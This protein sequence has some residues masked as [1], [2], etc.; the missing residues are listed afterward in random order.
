VRL[1]RPVTGGQK[2]NFPV[3]LVGA[4]PSPEDAKVASGLARTG[5]EKLLGRGDFLAVARG[6]TLRFQAAFISERALT[7]LLTGAP[8]ALLPAKATGAAGWTALPQRVLKSLRRV[9]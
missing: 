8:V 2:A 3:R 6:E 5:A 4:V 9:K 1:T 7:S